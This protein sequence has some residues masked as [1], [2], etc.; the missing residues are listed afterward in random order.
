[1]VTASTQ[2]FEHVHDK[3]EER[4]TNRTSRSKPATLELK[5]QEKYFNLMKNGEKVVEARPCYKSLRHYVKGDLIKFVNNE[6]ETESFVASSH[7]AQNN[8]RLF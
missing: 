7:C 3:R 2:D 4:V 1:M 8:L 6:D 5:V